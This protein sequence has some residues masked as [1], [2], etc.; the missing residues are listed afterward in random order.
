M[1]VS[2]FSE[3]KAYLDPYFSQPTKQTIRVIINPLKLKRWFWSTASYFFS[4]YPLL[5][6]FIVVFQLLNHVQLGDNMDCSTSGF[7]ILHYLLEF[8]Q[9]HLHVVDVAIQLSHPLFYPNSP[10]LNL[11]QHQGLFQSVSSLH[12]VAKV[13]EFQLSVSVLPENIQGWFP[14][15]LTGLI[16]L[17]FKGHSSIFS[18]I[19]FQM[20]QFFRAQPSLWSNSHICTCIHTSVLSHFSCVQLFVT[21]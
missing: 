10:A 18:G 14:L 17:L 7:P 21:L 2:V 11:S 4:L 5:L 19:T 12:Q 8:A 20:H 6:S 13:L 9:T 16:S 1:V 3:C 15:G